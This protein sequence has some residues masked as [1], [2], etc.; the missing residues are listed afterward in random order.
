[1]DI[2]RI[3]RRVDKLIL[4]SRDFLFGMMVVGIIL[5]LLGWY[6]LY[7]RHDSWPA[8]YFGILLI[9][10][11]LFYPT[12]NIILDYKKKELVVI[13]EP[14]APVFS[15]KKVYH[16]KDIKQVYPELNLKETFSLYRNRL[17]LMENNGHTVI[18]HKSQFSEDGF[19]LTYKYVEYLAKVLD[20]KV[21]E[22]KR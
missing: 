2:M 9:L 20:D 15:R 11:A 8:I 18:L 22:L 12:K 13:R 5:L 10:I 3:V 6:Y 17:M 19:A 4:G 21:Q 1:M 16:V 14:I 7:Y